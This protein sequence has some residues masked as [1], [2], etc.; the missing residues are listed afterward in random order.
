[1][2]IDKEGFNKSIL[3]LSKALKACTPQDAVRASGLVNYTAQTAKI[4]EENE[5]VIGLI[6]ALENVVSHSRQRN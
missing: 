5:K 6:R 1:M 2:R 3:E 4:H